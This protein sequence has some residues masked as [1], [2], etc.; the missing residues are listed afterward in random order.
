MKPA[1]LQLEDFGLPAAGRPAP[2]LYSEAEL[3]ARCEAA[4]AEGRRA[5][6]AAAAAA[7]DKA[8][9]ALAIAAVAAFQ[10]ASASMDEARQW[11]LGALAPVLATL[12]DRLL[13]GLA[14]EGLAAAILAEFERLDLPGEAL[15]ITLAVAPAQLSA[16]AGMM[17]R[18]LPE[19]S[20]TLRADPALSGLRVELRLG[21]DR[22]RIL[23]PDAAIAAL[24][25]ALAD[26]IPLPQQ[27]RDL[28]DT[29]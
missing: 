10:T 13:P 22:A 27:E 6:E 17:G 8:Q 12:V 29:A 9:E 20:F 26:H 1:A 7:R 21:A 16:L 11:A 14:R 23:D 25:A 4:R 2:R 24:R 19:G 18:L 15:P 3:A 28:A 5:A